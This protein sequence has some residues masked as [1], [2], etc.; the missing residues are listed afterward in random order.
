MSLPYNHDGEGGP[1][2]SLIQLLR[3][4]QKVSPRATSPS[5]TARRLK[6][7]IVKPGTIGMAQS[8]GAVREQAITRTQGDNEAEERVWSCSGGAH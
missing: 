6:E 1:G 3:L 4:R 7:S 8:V 5:I 2:M